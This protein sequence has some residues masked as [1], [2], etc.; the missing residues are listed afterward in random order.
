M[1]FIIRFVITAVAVILLLAVATIA[2]GVYGYNQLE[3]DFDG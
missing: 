1:K 3:T 2:L